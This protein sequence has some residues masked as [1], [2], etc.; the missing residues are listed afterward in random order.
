MSYRIET[1]PTRLIDVWT[2]ADGRRVT[3]RPV[4]PQDAELEQALV[5]SLSPASRY[6]RF[7]APIRELPAD[8]LQRMTQVDYHRHQALIVESFSGEHA[9]AVAEAR[10]V[11]DESGQ[12]GEFAVVV[13]DDWQRLGLARRLLESLMR[14]AAEEGLQRLVGDVLA[15]N[16]AMLALVR[17]LGFR[18][19]PHPD[20]GAQIVRVQRDLQA[21]RGAALEP[22]PGRAVPAAPAARVDALH[23]AAVA[24][25]R[26]APVTAAPAAME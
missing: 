3:L 13:A 23:A 4:L 22:A 14:S 21:L 16:T 19:L 11:V 8:W 20:G 25:L 10:F 6:Q 15:T 7:F 1:Y 2:L 18:V 17:G 24:A 26:A 5:R 12:Q 9:I